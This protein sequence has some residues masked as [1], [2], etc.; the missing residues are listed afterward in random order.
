MIQVDDKNFD[1]E[2]Y[3]ETKPVLIAFTAQW[4][5]VCQEHYKPE[6]QKMSEKYGTHI[7]FCNVDIDESPDTKAYFGVEKAPTTILIFNGQEVA[8]LNAAWPEDV[9]VQFINDSLGL[10]LV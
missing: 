6:L 1:T 5:W 3:D 9:V 10:G 8:Q 4:C 2:V 7:K